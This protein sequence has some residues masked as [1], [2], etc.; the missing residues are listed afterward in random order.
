MRQTLGVIELDQ[1]KMPWEEKIGRTVNVGEAIG[2]AGVMPSCE[3][4]AGDVRSL[5]QGGA[6][7]DLR[8]FRKRFAAGLD[9]AVGALGTEVPKTFKLGGPIDAA[10]GGGVRLGSLSLIGGPHE[11]V[12][13]LLAR[14]AL[15]LSEQYPMVY[16]PLREREHEAAARLLRLEMRDEVL[17]DAEGR[18]VEAI[19]ASMRLK[20]RE[21]GIFGTDNMTLD[22]L[23]SWLFDGRVQEGGVL[24]NVVLV[25]DGLEMLDDNRPM[26][27]I[28]RDL[29]NLIGPTSAILA[30][31]FAAGDCD[32]GAA[33]A[34][35][36]NNADALVRIFRKNQVGEG[37][38]RLA[39]ER[40]FSWG[41]TR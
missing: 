32:G 3:A 6:M 19:L 22:L 20:K 10:L 34:G 4:H 40:V 30:G 18:Q 23:T 12:T 7:F 28:L 8:D 31:C 13:D 37:D 24:E 21:L 29:R 9:D 17:D 1:R 5:K 16:V 35:T 33:F 15:G 26:N 2:V 36:H 14:A 25:I 41:S 38:A 39:Y 27:A 11:T